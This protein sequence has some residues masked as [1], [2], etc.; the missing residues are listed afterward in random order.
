[1]LKTDDYLTTLIQAGPDAFSNMYLVTLTISKKDNETEKNKLSA[2][3]ETFNIPPIEANTVDLPYQNSHYTLAV[4]SSNIEKTSQFNFRIDHNFSLYKKLCEL[5]ALRENSDLKFDDD[6]DLEKKQLIQIDVQSI[7]SS[8]ATSTTTS[9]RKWTFENCEII[10]MSSF[11]YRYSDA[12]A[13]T[14]NVK[15]TYGNLKITS[16]TT[17]TTNTTSAKQDK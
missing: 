2:R 11:T 9:P 16:V 7:D 13:L 4:P 12:S 8:D 15:F 14:A 6:N 1:M 5:I 10:S 17:K 3:I